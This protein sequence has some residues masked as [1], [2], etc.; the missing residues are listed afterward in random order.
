MNLKFNGDKLIDAFAVSSFFSL[1]FAP[2]KPQT[3]DR[4]QQHTI[5]IAGGVARNPLVRLSNPITLDFLDGEHIA[6]AGLTGQERV[7]W[8]ICLRASI[9][10][11][12]V[13]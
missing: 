1:I 3:I 10:C 8:S 2:F 4:M 5:H 12:T 11:A 6:I 13:R 7:C 9:P